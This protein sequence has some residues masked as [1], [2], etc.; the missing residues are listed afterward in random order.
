MAAASAIEFGQRFLD[1]DGNAAAR[2]R[3]DVA[4]VIL[5]ARC[6]DHGVDAGVGRHPVRR[7]RGREIAREVAGVERGEIRARRVQ[8]RRQ[9]IAHRHEVDAPGAVQ[10]HQMLQV[11]AAHAAGAEDAET[12]P[13]F[14]SGL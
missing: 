12:G 5:G 6:D 11:H 2:E 9:R 10:P 13:R 3:H 4:G 7:R 1:Q 14:D 8:R